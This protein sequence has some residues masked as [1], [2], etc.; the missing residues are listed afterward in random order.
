[1]VS[2]VAGLAT[3]SHSEAWD[4]TQRPLIKFGTFVIGGAATGI[5]ITFRLRD[6]CD[7]ALALAN[8]LQRGFQH[9]ESFIHLLVGHDERHQ[10]ANHVGI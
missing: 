1:M 8:H 10:Y 6:L 4:S 3:S 7:C 9:V 5:A 2:P